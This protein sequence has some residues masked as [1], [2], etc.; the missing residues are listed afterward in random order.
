MHVHFLA[1]LA[2]IWAFLAFLVGEGPA[3]LT[4]EIARGVFNRL[5]TSLALFDLFDEISVPFAI[6]MACPYNRTNW[7]FA[8]FAFLEL[9]A[10]ASGNVNIVNIVKKA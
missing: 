10:Y 2:G 4:C 3:T 7:N 9:W 1:G 6:N 5:I 8:V